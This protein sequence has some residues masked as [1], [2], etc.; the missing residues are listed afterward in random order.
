M[1]F[2]TV[3]PLD[4]TTGGTRATLSGYLQ[5]QFSLGGQRQPPRR[6]DDGRWE[7][8][9]V[10]PGETHRALVAADSRSVEIITSKA[11]WRQTLNTFHR[12]H[13]YH[14]G[15]LYIL[16]A[17]LYDLASGA[18]IVFP[19]SGIYLWYKLTQK[20]LLGWIMLALSFTYTLGTMLYLIYGA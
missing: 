4:Y 19:L 18:M 15:G 3:W 17:I 10:H 5:E 13:G 16:W 2:H 8:R 6:L 20:R 12:L 14:G 9:D 1:G 11:G 7:F